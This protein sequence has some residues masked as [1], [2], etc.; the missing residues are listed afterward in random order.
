[1]SLV[2]IYKGSMRVKCDRRMDRWK[3][4]KIIYFIYFVGIKIEFILN[5]C[6]F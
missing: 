1:M 4:I 5:I 6:D 3:R 2:L